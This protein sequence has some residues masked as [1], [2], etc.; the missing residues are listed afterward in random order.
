MKRLENNK[1]RTNE[2]KNDLNSTNVEKAKWENLKKRNKIKN[3][4]NT[5]SKKIH[6]FSRRTGK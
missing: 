6:E 3:S 4:E 2:I 1:K 5:R